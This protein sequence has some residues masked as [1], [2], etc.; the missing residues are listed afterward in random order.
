MAQKGKKPATQQI[1]YG[2]LTSLH[3]ANSQ[4]S[5]EPEQQEVAK[6]PVKDTTERPSE[7]QTEVANDLAEEG[8][9]PVKDPARN[10]IVDS[11]GGH[12]RQL[13]EGAQLRPHQNKNLPGGA[14][15][16]P[17]HDV[18][19]IEVD[20]PKVPD[21]R[22]VEVIADQTTANRAND[23]SN[24]ISNSEIRAHV[25]VLRKQ[26]EKAELKAKLE[27]L[28]RKKAGGFVGERNQM[29]GNKHVCQL[30]LER[31]KHV[32]DPNVYLVLS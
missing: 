23:L 18:D 8:R 13:I 27:Y 2:D 28:K 4:G 11:V 29:D 24:S 12:G 14:E 17:Q 7:M 31:S 32:Q 19:T 3:K 6:T 20:P 9:G 5:Q 21:S 16:L 10:L 1:L 25:A 15:S 26:K 30:S 22:I